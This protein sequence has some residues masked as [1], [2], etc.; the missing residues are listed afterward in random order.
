MTP[1]IPLELFSRSV[2]GTAERNIT[3][4]ITL[5][6]HY[7]PTIVLLSSLARGLSSLA[8]GTPS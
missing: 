5:S 3:P 6:S 1:Q 7:L 2:L 8:S 4:L